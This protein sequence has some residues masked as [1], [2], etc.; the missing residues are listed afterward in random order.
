MFV[1]KQQMN[2]KTRAL[3]QG[4]T[5]GRAEGR[6]GK[7]RDTLPRV[8]RTC[9]TPRAMCA[10]ANRQAP[11][12]GCCRSTRVEAADPHCSSSAQKR[13]SACL[14]EAGAMG[15]AAAA[16]SD[17]GWGSSATPRSSCLLLPLRRLPGGAWPREDPG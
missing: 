3:R 5:K 14:V 10:R 7:A 1:N 4:Q 2:N 6:H 8:A 16:A 12:F 13:V 11:A 17:Q 9:K 15:G